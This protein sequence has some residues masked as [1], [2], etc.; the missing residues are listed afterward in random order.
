M[1]RIIISIEVRSR[2]KE[3]V[4]LLFEKD[5]FGFKDSAKSYVDKIV[6]TILAIPRLKHYQT[7]DTS[8]GSYFVRHKANS[9]TTYY[10]L[11]DIKGNRYYITN[12]ISNHEARY[13][14][15]LPSWSQ[16]IF[17][18]LFWPKAFLS[19][20]QPSCCGGLSNPFQIDRFPPFQF[21]SKLS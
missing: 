6:E 21:G 11:F 14:K 7:K 2:L 1:E 8:R 10:I 12:I 17:L 9:N 5:Y 18:T 15:Y 19:T 3:L 16:V 13:S 4:H 20:L